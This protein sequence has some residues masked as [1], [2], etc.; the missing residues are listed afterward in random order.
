MTEPVLT[1]ELTELPEPKEFKAGIRRAP[2]RGFTLNAH[3]TRIALANA[4]RDG[5]TPGVATNDMAAFPYSD[6]DWALCPSSGTKYLRSSSTKGTY[7]VST[8]GTVTQTSSG[9]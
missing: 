4:L 5:T 9:Y 1:V 6:G 3:D 2:D 7:T 8:D